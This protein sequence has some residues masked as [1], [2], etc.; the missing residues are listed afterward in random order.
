MAA[1]LTCTGRRSVCI[2]SPS[3]PQGQSKPRCQPRPSFQ[4]GRCGSAC[5]SLPPA[6]ERQQTSGRLLCDCVP[7]RLLRVQHRTVQAVPV[8]ATACRLLTSASFALPVAVSSTLEDLTAGRQARGD[9]SV[10]VQ[11]LEHTQ[12][13]AE[14]IGSTPACPPTS[15]TSW[16]PRSEGQPLTVH[17]H[18]A[19]HGNRRRRQQRQ[20]RKHAQR[21]AVLKQV[22]AT[23]LAP[24]QLQPHTCTRCIPGG[25]GTPALWR[26][27]PRCGGRCATI[28]TCDRRSVPSAA[29]AR[30]AGPALR[31]VQP[32]RRGCTIDFDV[33][34]LN[35]LLISMHTELAALT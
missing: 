31:R 10:R 24:G 27:Q 23:V 29:A 35:A 20:L 1:P 32:D 15:T 30:S 22:L 7:E 17:V 25:A 34:L 14:H 9:A 8:T 28:Q 16:P 13:S 11:L 18:N 26:P 2:G 33:L 4:R 5:G 21:P 3:A 19:L 6:K 12:A